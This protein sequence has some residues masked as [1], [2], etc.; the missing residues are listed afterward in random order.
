MLNYIDNLE[1]SSDYNKWEPATKLQ[2]KPGLQVTVLLPTH[3]VALGKSLLLSF[4]STIYAWI[5]IAGIAILNAFKGKDLDS[6]PYLPGSALII[7]QKQS[8]THCLSIMFRYI[9][10]IILRLCQHGKHESFSHEP[11]ITPSRSTQN[12]NSFHS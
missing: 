7:S 3:Y 11:P 12:K 8:L 1:H 4:S 10:A 2:V 9:K 5:G 6:Y